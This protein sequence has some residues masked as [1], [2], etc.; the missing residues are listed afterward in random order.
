M[1]ICWKKKNTDCN[2]FMSNHNTLTHDPLKITDPSTHMH[3]LL[4]VQFAA[5]YEDLNGGRGAKSTLV[6]LI[7]LD[8][9]HELVSLWC[10]FDIIFTAEQGNPTN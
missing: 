9:R 1:T 7:L 6:T 4:I 10:N 2:V 3:Q 5:T 8:E